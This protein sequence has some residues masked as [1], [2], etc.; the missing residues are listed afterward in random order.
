MWLKEEQWN[1][2]SFEVNEFSGDNLRSLA[3]GSHVEFIKLDSSNEESDWK[4]WT[5]E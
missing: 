4:I 1:E 5:R 2:Q 3:P